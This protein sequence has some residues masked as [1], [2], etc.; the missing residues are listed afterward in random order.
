MIWLEVLVEGASDTPTIKE[1]LE[2]KFQLIDGTHFRIHPHKGK[3]KLPANPLARPDLKHQG[4]LDQLPAKLRG[5]GK[6]LGENSVVLVVVDVD[7]QPS[8]QLL[9]E[10]NAMLIALPVKPRVLFRLAVE[11]TESWFIADINALKLAYPSVLSKKFLNG[12]APDQII[13]AWE[14]LAQALRIN[15]KMVSGSTKVE[16]A[17]KIAPHL[18]L[19]NPNSPSFRYLINGIAEVVEA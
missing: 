7:K 13:G 17:K 8:D 1:V 6:S 12:I 16:W 15:P 18:D 11:E 3:G 19:E 4:L 2:R 5:F 10:L 14:K 9:S